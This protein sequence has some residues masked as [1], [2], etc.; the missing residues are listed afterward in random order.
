MDGF[1]RHNDI[2]TKPALGYFNKNQRLISCKIRSL[3]WSFRHFGVRRVNTAWNS[4]LT[5]SY[6][7][8]KWAKFGTKI[9]TRFCEITIF[10]S[11]RFSLTHPVYNNESKLMYHLIPRQTYVESSLYPL[12]QLALSHFPG[13]CESHLSQLAPHSE[14]ENSS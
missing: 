6:V 2:T 5:D 3:S 12:S 13:P 9:F 1:Q 4:R 10:V 8:S 7:L 11:G 14:N